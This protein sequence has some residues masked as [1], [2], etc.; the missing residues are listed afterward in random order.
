MTFDSILS[1]VKKIF[2]VLKKISILMQYIPKVLVLY[3]NFQLY[4]CY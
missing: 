1:L 2:D 4:E 3:M